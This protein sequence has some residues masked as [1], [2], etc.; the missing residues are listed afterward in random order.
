MPDLIFFIFV[1][2]FILFFVSIFAFILWGIFTGISNQRRIDARNRA[3]PLL[4]RE[5]RL[6]GKRQDVRGG[7]ETSAT[8]LYY[9]TFEFTSG[10]REEFWVTGE[11]Y[12]LLIEGDRGMLQSQGTWYKGFNRLS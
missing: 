10:N 11:D 3:S 8:T 12:G 4:N 9:L 2:I 5:A 6:V 7:G 1:P